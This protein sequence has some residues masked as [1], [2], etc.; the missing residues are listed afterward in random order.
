MQILYERCAGI[1]IGKD[2]IAVAVRAPGEGSDGPRATDREADMAGPAQPA[3]VSLLQGIAIR[4]ECALL[5][6]PRSAARTRARR[7]LRQPAAV[8]HRPPLDVGCGTGEH[9]L[10]AAGVG[11]DTTGVDLAGKALC[12]RHAIG[13]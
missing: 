12:R 9:E 3:F 11:L 10:M 8:G 6:V 5:P 2:I 13:D 1:D 4:G 7:P